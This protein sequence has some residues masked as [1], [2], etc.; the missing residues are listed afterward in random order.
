MTEARDHSLDTLLDLDGTAL[1][2]DLE[3][4]HWVKF[5]VTVVPVS[6]EKP[7]GFDYS[8]TLHGPDSEWLAGFDNAYPVGRQRRG[9]PQ[10]P[11]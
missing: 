2:V 5:V 6:P 1:V 11:A 7:Q 9:E 10:D 8:L 4:S 3:G